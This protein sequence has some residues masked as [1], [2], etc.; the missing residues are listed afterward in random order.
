MWNSTTT[1]SGLNLTA[2]GHEITITSAMAGTG[3]V[4]FSQLQSMTSLSD[5]RQSMQI[6]VD[7]ATENVRTLRLQIASKDVIN[8]FALTQISV[9]AS[10]DGADPVL[11]FIAQRTDAL[12]I[13]SSTETE[14]FI[15]EPTVNLTFTSDGELQINVA[16]SGFVTPDALHN[17]ENRITTEY[18]TAD[19]TTLT[20]ANEYTDEKVEQARSDA[21]ICKTTCKEIELPTTGQSN[22]DYYHISDFDISHNGENLHGSAVWDG[23]T[24]AWD[25]A[26]DLY[27]QPDNI[28]IT[29]RSSDGALQVAD[30]GVTKAKLA[31]ALQTLLNY[32]DTGGSIQALITALQNALYG[33]VDKISGKGLS[34]NDYTDAYK[35][36]LDG[37]AAGA[38]VNAVTSVAGRTGAVALTKDDVGLSNVANQKQVNRAKTVDDADEVSVSFNKNTQHALVI[39]DGVSK[40]LANSADI[41]QFSAATP[42]AI[43]GPSAVGTSSAAARAD[44]MHPVSSQ[45]ELGMEATSDNTC[46]IDFHSSNGSGAKDYDARIICYAGEQ[47]LSI[48]AA[49]GVYANE[50]RIDTQGSLIWSATIVAT[51]ETTVN[52]ANWQ[53]CS[54]I[55]FRATFTSNFVQSVTYPVGALKTFTAD[56]NFFNFGAFSG[57][58][59]FALSFRSVDANNFR[60]SVNMATTV[61]IY[62]T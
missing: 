14:R 32:V 31:S 44:H 29:E 9:F 46:Y 23:D 30:C 26:T 37:I 22:G 3:Q 55:T 36:K 5:P 60:L 34:A 21:M 51:G 53:S 56:F 39:G 7:E 54:W 35:T 24:S 20:A 52:A 17:A 11:Y 12:L 41:V 38:Q 16:E 10:I 61:D 58:S 47:K 45:F 49:G 59:N 19:T 13:P 4:E 2:T 28:T 1:Q 50:K 25:F 6:I 57:G 40:Q 18:Q 15:Y 8:G 48:L 27:R 42:A 33:K 62:I 43:V